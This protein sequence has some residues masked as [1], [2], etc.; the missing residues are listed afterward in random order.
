MAILQ[1][2]KKKI[3]K[4]LECNHFC[5]LKT[6]STFGTNTINFVFSFSMVMTRL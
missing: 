2:I 6:K 5:G 1:R 4:K 3:L